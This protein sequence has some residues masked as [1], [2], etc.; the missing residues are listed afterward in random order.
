MTDLKDWIEKL[1]DQKTA[2]CPADY[3][4]RCELAH[5]LS[6][7][8]KERDEAREE[9]ASN[10]SEYL[11]ERSARM[12]ANNREFAAETELSAL[13]ALVRRM[14]EG[15]ERSRDALHAAYER[16]GHADDLAEAHI[17]ASLLS[18]AKGEGER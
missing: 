10:W 16:T 8:E 15:L 18:E 7:L 4:E 5:A 2:T 9:A 6:A 14:V 11:E 17:A 1:R 13:K 12:A 3:E